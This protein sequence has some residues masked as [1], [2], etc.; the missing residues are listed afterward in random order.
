[1]E[2]KINRLPEVNRETILSEIIRVDK[3]I[4]KKM[5]SKKDFLSLS[6]VSGNTINK[7]F[8]SWHAALVAAG[9]EEKSNQRL[10]TFKL[11]KQEG[12]FLTD[13]EIVEEMKAIAKKIGKDTITTKDLDEYSEKISGSTIRNRFGWRKGLLLAGLK[14]SSLGKRYSDIDCFNNLLKVWTYYGRQPRLSEMRIMPS[15]VGPKAYIKRWG[16]WIKAL[17]NFVDEIEKTSEKPIEQNL[18]PNQTKLKK[19]VIKIEDRREIPLGIRYN[20]LKRDY[21]KCTICGDNPAKRHQCEL[22]V[23]HIIPF[24]KGGKTNIDNLRTLCKNCN[25]GKSAK[26]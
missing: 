15:I 23:D 19:D 24:A 18:I 9:I 1:M 14:I 17:E 4:D 25:L 13:E 12:R 7:Y 2:F 20:V 10:P 5:F 8:G 26:L 16:S 21:F 6:R 3:I 22:Q 11:I